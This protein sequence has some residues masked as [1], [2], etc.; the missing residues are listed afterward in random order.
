MIIEDKTVVTLSYSLTAEEDGVESHIEKT[1]VER[2]FVFM[3]GVSHALPAFEKNLAGKKI[4]DRFDFI[5]NADEAYG[6]SDMKNI[7]RVP[8]S[9]FQDEQGNVKPGL[10]EEGR[11]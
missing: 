6:K 1:E 10:L 8:L 7:G 4:G 9:I 3:F 11:V 2:P 5:L